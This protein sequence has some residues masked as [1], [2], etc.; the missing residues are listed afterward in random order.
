LLAGLYRILNTCKN[1][2]CQPLNIHRVNDIL[3]AEV[4]TAKTLIPES[5]VLDFKIFINNFSRHKL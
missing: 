1:H 2:V 5:T 3:Q 4:H